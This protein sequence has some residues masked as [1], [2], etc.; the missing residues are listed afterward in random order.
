[1]L[2][3]HALVTGQ[4]QPG[5]ELAG[6]A[7]RARPVQLVP[8]RTTSRCPAARQASHRA[9]ASAPAWSCRPRPQRLSA[10]S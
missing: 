3:A 1:V 10:R 9:L 2:V 6:P 4:V 8:P 5:D 7:R